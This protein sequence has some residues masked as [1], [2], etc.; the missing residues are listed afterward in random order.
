[1]G[2]ILPLLFLCLQ[3]PSCSE[4]VTP[5][6]TT[7]PAQAEEEL[8]DALG[9]VLAADVAGGFDSNDRREATL[10]AGVKIGWPESLRG[11]YPY[12]TLDRNMTLDLG[13]DRV[14]GRNGFSGE[15]SLM[16][17]VARFPAPRTPAATYAR[18]YVEPGVGYRVGAG[19]FGSYA[20]AKAMMALF[21]DDRLTRSDAPP[22]VFLE[23]QRR[24]PLAA[25]LHGDTRFVIG[26]MLAVCHHCGLN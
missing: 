8:S 21:S 17:P 14:Q 1:M 2:T 4:T 18:V 25:P 23:I 15:L 24:F 3:G 26:L 5:P 12:S 20:S 10:F 16:L 6:R 7:N 22:S 9:I 13:Y 11:G 19:D